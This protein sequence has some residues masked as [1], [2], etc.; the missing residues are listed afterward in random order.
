MSAGGGSLQLTDADVAQPQRQAVVLEADG[1]GLRTG[2][3]LLAVEAHLVDDLAVEADGHLV[4]LGGDLHVV[5]LAGWLR[6]IL[7]RRNAGD[8]AAA[9]VDRKSVV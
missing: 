1:A 5:P 4:A 3:Q 7:C 2:L 8:D 6:G 9:V